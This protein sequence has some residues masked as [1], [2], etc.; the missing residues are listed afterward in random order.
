PSSKTS[1]SPIET[2][3]DGSFDSTWGKP[4]PQNF[5]LSPT[6][7]LQGM[8]DGLLGKKVGSRV[9]VVIPPALAFGTAGSPQLGIGP[10]DSLIFVFDILDGFGGAAAADGT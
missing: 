3:D 9:L 2:A 10:D 1:P 6:S 4:A 5:A 8:Y 7:L